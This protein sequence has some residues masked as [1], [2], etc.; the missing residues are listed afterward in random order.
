[1]DYRDLLVKYIQLV[2]SCEGVSCVALGPCDPTGPT[3]TPE[4]RDELW[5]LE[6][7]GDNADR[8]RQLVREV[9]GR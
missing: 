8:T 6:E 7:E 5:Y 9:R 2:K 4:E 1:M 3:L